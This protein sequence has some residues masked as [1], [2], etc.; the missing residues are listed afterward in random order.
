MVRSHRMSILL[1]LESDLFVL[2]NYTNFKVYT[3]GAIVVK[4]DAKSLKLIMEI[5]KRM[6]GEVT[7]LDNDQLEDFTFGEMMK[8]AKTGKTVSRDSI[9]QKLK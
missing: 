9:M 8:E 2:L 1:N 4:S 6:G 5:A 7:K 3:M